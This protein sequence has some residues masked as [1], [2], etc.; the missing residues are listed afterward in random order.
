MVPPRF[1][2]D[3][4]QTNVPQL[5][6]ISQRTAW[7]SS[8]VP[9][10]ASSGCA[11][12]SPCGP[13][14]FEQN[15]GVSSLYPA[16]RIPQGVVVIGSLFV[17]LSAGA[18]IEHFAFGVPFYDRNTGQPESDLTVAIVSV[19]LA[20]VGALMVLTGRAVLRAAARHERNRTRKPKG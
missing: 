17:V 15:R 11:L 14:W 16:R 9:A 13:R 12:W 5:P 19:I 1:R 3:S 2:A 4:R 20:S 7:P 6:T 10:G 18:G 8:Q